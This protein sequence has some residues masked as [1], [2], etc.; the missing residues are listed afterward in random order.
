MIIVPR[1]YGSGGSTNTEAPLNLIEFGEGAT[2]ITRTAGGGPPGARVFNK[3]G[4]VIPG[5]SRGEHL[6]YLRLC[7]S[8]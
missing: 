5:S 8:E 3:H 4:D 1:Y 7:H 6:D 2:S